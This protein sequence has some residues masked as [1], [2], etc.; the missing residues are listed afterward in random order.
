MQV[1]KCD[2]CGLELKREER[3]RISPPKGGRWDDVDTMLYI[4]FATRASADKGRI[5]TYGPDIC[6]KCAAGKIAES[7]G[8]ML[9]PLTH[10]SIAI[11]A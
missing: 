2:Y 9:V 4:T 3:L 11:E 7:L 5:E 6:Y 8:M 1:T 10:T